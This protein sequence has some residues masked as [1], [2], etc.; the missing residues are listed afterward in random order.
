MKLRGFALIA[1]L[2]AGCEGAGADTVSDPGATVMP[3][4][5][6]GGD[7][8]SIS[9]QLTL[10]GGFRFSDVGYDIS[11]NGFHRTGSINVAASTTV[12]FVI[13]AIPLGTGYTL[14]LTAHD[15]DH[16][17]ASCAGAA[18]FDLRSAQVVDVPVRLSCH[19]L[20]PAAQAV[21]VPR[22][23]GALAGAL[24]LVIGARAARRR[25]L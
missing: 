1:L 22:W 7:V 11:G 23:A 14:Q 12:S 13:A 20:A 3:G 4:T 8:G 17:L 6:G 21:P 19:E 16:K 15:V 5:A 18:P 2:L 9:A 24:L 25:V 10:G